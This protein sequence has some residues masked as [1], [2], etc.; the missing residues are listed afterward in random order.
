M[1]KAPVTPPRRRSLFVRGY[2]RPPLEGAI[3][4]KPPGKANACKVLVFFGVFV[5]G[6]F[7]LFFAAGYYSA[8]DRG[9]LVD[10]FSFGNSPLKSEAIVDQSV[11]LDRKPPSIHNP[12]KRLKIAVAVT[13]TRD[14]PYLDGAAVLQHSVR[15]TRSQ[16]DIDMVAIVHSDVQTTRPALKALGFRVMEFPAPILSKEIQGKHLR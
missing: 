6:S 2:D 16:H 10:P 9:Q 14:G 8:R 5:A 3:L 7:A 12:R 4:S 1:I 15:M 13:V 11:Q